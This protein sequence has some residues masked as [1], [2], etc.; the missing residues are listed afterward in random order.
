MVT[1]ALCP[2]NGE[3]L[4]IPEAGPPPAPARMYRAT[5]RAQGASTLAAMGTGLSTERRD[6]RNL[7]RHAG[8]C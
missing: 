3:R 4:V 5:Q 2:R 7:I 1:T 8:Y 6:A